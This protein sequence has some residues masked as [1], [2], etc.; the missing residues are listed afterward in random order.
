MKRRRWIVLA[1]ACGMTG[2]GVV[3][4]QF[5]YYV[6]PKRFRVVEA[7]R[8]YRGGWQKS[9]P[10]RRIL[11]EHHIKTLL[12]V[13]CNPP[14]PDADGE[15]PIT[16]ELGVAWHKILMPGTGLGTYDQLDEAA[17]V[18]AEPSNWPVFVHC[19]AGVHRTNMSIAAYRLK[20]C[21][22][23]LDQALDEMARY[24]FDRKRDAVQ[25]E[26]L[27]GYVEQVRKQTATLPRS[28]P[29]FVSGRR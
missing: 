21:G 20:H 15:G 28:N 7:G 9:G 11:Q 19:A 13:A 17:N 4:N 2:L 26:H 6:W 16:R 22:W 27:Q 24:G 14:E 12:N 25:A 8:I 10:L 23:R 18:L 1:L 5:K 29:A 3:A